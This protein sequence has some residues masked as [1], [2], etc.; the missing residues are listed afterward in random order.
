MY[1]YG[2]DIPKFHIDQVRD[3]HSKAVG[4]REDILVN[5]IDFVESVFVRTTVCLIKSLPHLF[6]VT[7]V[8]TLM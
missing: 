7:M 3:L 5:G 4:Y 1:Y 8:D 6:I 2:R